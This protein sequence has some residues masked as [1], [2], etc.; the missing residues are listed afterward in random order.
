M[1]KTLNELKLA[2]ENIVA[3]FESNTNSV[4][5]MLV[6]IG[7]INAF[8]NERNYTEEEMKQIKFD[9]G[10]YDMIISVSEMIKEYQFLLN[11]LMGTD[12]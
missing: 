10:L 2:I 4:R 11:E 3:K 7:Q 9:L 5:K 8:L 12:Q 1:D 6:T